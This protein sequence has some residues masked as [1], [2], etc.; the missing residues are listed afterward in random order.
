VSVVSKSS[1]SGFQSC[2]PK[3]HP[4][5]NESSNGYGFEMFWGHCIYLPCSPFKWRQDLPPVS[6]GNPTWHESP[7]ITR[8]YQGECISI[9]KA[10][11][12][13]AALDTFC[14]HI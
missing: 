3:V 4:F 2:F 12:H 11:A 5:I 7:W 8:G 14:T 10:R 6:T 9:M 13:Q 1:R